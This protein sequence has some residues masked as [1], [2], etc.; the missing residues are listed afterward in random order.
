MTCFA[1]GENGDKDAAR[2]THEPLDLGPPPFRP[3]VRSSA[4]ILE[5]AALARARNSR[6]HFMSSEVKNR[7]LSHLGKQQTS[8]MSFD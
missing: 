2:S 7:L 5:R 6:V 4:N 3:R 1:D 8:K